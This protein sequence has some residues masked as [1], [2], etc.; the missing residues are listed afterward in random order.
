MRSSL[1]LNLELDQTL[2]LQSKS[3]DYNQ[4]SAQVENRDNAIIVNSVNAA[5]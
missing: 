5:L 3:F 4:A 1:D 2:R